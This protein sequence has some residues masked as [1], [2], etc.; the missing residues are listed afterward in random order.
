MAVFAGDTVK[1]WFRGT[2]FLQ[3]IIFDLSYRVNVGNAG[4]TTNAALN[5]LLNEVFGAGANGIVPQYL[6]CLP[7]QYI[8]DE[9]RAQVIKPV[10][11]A[12]TSQGVPAATVG[13][14]AGAATVACDSAT[15]N[16]RTAGAGRDQVSVLK[17]GPCPDGASAAGQLT[18][19][20]QALLGI[21]GTASIK[22]LLL[23]VSTIQLT[24][25]ILKPDGTTNNRDLVG[26]HIGTTS[27]VMTRRVVGRG[28]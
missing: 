10:R 1:I 4:V 25:C 9:I 8:M 28:E 6:A 15:I 19:A 18:P 11:S 22:A 26:F 27:R 17:V 23:P 13:T 7:P 12:Y 21:L 16:R 20:Y 5:E 3:R 2:C 24:S 14:H